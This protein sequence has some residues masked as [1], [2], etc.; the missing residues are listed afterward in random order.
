MKTN[1]KNI[2][3]TITSVH[4]VAI[5]IKSPKKQFKRSPKT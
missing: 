2:L 4:T 1:T 5:R 3:K